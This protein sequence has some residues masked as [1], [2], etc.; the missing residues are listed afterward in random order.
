MQPTLK[1]SRSIAHIWNL[2]V[3]KFAFYSYFSKIFFM[4]AHVHECMYVCVCVDAVMLPVCGYL[5]RLKEDVKSHG[6]G[7][8]DSCELLNVGSGNQM[9]ILY[10]SSKYSLSYYSSPWLVYLHKHLFRLLVTLEMSFNVLGS[11]SCLCILFCCQ[12]VLGFVIE[13]F[14]CWI[15]SYIHYCGIFF[16]YFL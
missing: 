16:W 13:T 3:N 10:K 5:Y 1:G 14:I 11:S 8:P 6:T 15:L 12:I 4:C 7:G 9:W 2:F